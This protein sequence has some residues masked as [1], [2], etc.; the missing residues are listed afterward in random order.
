MEIPSYP[1]DIEYNKVGISLKIVKRI[2]E[3]YRRYFYKYVDRMVTFSTFSKIF[4]VD[5]IKINNGVNINSIPLKNN[6]KKDTNIHL[7]AVAV[8]NVWHGYDRLIEGLRLYYDNNPETKV[9]FHV[10]GDGEDNESMN[11][12]SLVKKYRLNDYVLF[13]GFK[14]GEDLNK[15]FDYA[16]FAVGSIGIHRIGLTHTNP[17]KFSEYTARGIPFLY[18]G[19]YDIFENQP[20]IYKVT[21][22]DSPVDIV[23]LLS[24]IQKIEFTPGEIRKF[25]ERHLTWEIQMNKVI[26]EVLLLQ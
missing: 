15:L 10:V 9:Y 22:D 23:Q 1:Y 26:E 6:I 7:I 24:F 21:N 12:K 8:M 17:I 5:T 14:T 11:Y 3:F 20:F 13:Y 18:S 4:G 19:I 16:D 2:E 25:A